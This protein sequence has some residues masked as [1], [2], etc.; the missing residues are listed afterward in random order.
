MGDHELRRTGADI[1]Y[2]DFA[3]RLMADGRGG[4]MVLV[5]HATGGGGSAPFEL[6]GPDAVEGCLEALSSLGAAGAPERARELGAT[7]FRHLLRD[8]VR[9][10]FLRSLAHQDRSSARGL[11]LR[12]VFDL[13]QP[14]VAALAALP[15]ELLFDPDQ[16]AHLSLDRHLPVVRFLDVSSSVWPLAEE[17]PLSVLVVGCSPRGLPAVDVERERDGIVEALSEHGGLT[18]VCA[19]DGTLETMIGL[20]GAESPHVLHFLGHGELDPDTGQGV[21]VFETPNGAAHVV[22]ASLLAEHLRGFR[23]VRLVVL[24]ACESA[25]VPRDRGLDPYSSVATALVQQGIPAAVAMQSPISNGAAVAFSHTFYG[26]LAREEAV[27]TAVAEGRLAIRRGNERSCEWAVPALYLRSSH[28]RILPQ[29]VDRQP[30]SEDLWKLVQQYRKPR[31]IDKKTR[32]FVGRRFVFDEIERFFSQNT[33]GYFTIT[34]EPGIGKSALVAELARQHDL[35]YHFNDLAAGIYR[36]EPFLAHVCAQLIL[37]YRLPYRSLPSMA[38]RDNAFLVNLLQEARERLPAGERLVILID[39]LDEVKAEG[40]PRGTNLLYLPQDLPAG[41][42]MVLT[43]R[44]QRSEEQPR[45]LCEQDGMF[46]DSSSDKNRAD[47]R[48]Y[49]ESHLDRPGIVAY[50]RVQSLG[51]GE[52][53]EGLEEKSEGN[54]MYLYYV[55][56]ALEAKNNDQSSFHDLPKGLTKYYEIQWQRMRGESSVAEWLERKLPV[57]GA[58]ARID[59]PM[60]LNVLALTAG[61]VDRRWVREVL[62][63]WRPFLD[64][65]SVEDPKTGRRYEV[66]NI[67]HQS[68]HDF[69][70]GKDE[71]ADVLW[72]EERLVLDATDDR[73]LDQF[74]FRRDDERVQ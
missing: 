38:N 5:Q 69:L 46:L 62:Q 37:R 68:F 70:T 32:G 21:L 24:S 36:H 22:S 27:D 58:L 26:A 10:S 40:L 42:Y 43:G 57:L 51:E 28:S 44:P 63:E 3:L 1:I 59:K 31:W 47:V 29:L 17:P 60:S 39:A 9:D 25:T 52:F 12:L 53:V 49:V 45:F 13:G 7:L 15:W 74:P 18:P 8:R 14:G 55:L 56:P 72:E 35:V 34:G 54:F 23:S 66:Y 33:H 19:P 2:E 64:V 73:L 65:S 41:V 6:S 50:R 48:S 4:F 67:Y 30:P 11:R 71:V 16:R 20:V 61:S